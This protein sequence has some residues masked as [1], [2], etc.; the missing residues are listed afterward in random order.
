MKSL[1]SV[2]LFVFITSAALAQTP[3]SIALR[4]LIIEQSKEGGKLDYFTRIKGKETL[5]SQVKPGIY[6]QNIHIAWFYWG[7]A[8]YINGIKSLD[9]VISIF[10]E[11][12][13][14]DPGRMEYEHIKLGFADRDKKE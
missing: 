3:D 9:D 11:W 2:F 10:K 1:L 5:G 6:A 14:R 8:N 4:K 7:K 13:Q 12:K